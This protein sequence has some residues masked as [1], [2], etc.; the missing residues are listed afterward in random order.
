MKYTFLF[1]ISLF[2]FFCDTNS[3]NDKLHPLYSIINNKKFTLLYI[4]KNSCVSCIRQIEN[5]INKL[6]YRKDFFIYSNDLDISEIHKVYFDTNQRILNHLSKYNIIKNLSFILI[7][8]DRKIISLK[9]ITPE[10][11][12]T[13]DF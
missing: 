13:F 9:Y 11:K 1:L 7:Y 6:K 12:D 8:D 4:N 5:K 3:D 10:N 2:L